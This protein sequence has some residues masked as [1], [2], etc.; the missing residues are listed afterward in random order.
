MSSLA[1]K[2]LTLMVAW[3]EFFSF[4]PEA[5]DLL[6]ETIWERQNVFEP[7]TLHD[8]NLVLTG[9]DRRVKSALPILICR[10]PAVG[11]KVNIQIRPPWKSNWPPRVET[12]RYPPRQ[13]CRAYRDSRGLRAT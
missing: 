4:R 13:D 2:H 6:V 11:S 5:F 12:G 8:T 3:R 10:C 7:A 1:Q 9:P